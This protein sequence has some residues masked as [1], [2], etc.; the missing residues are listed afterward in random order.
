[1]TRGRDCRGGVC[2]VYDNG[3]YHYGLDSW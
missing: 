1:C 2:S 3:Y